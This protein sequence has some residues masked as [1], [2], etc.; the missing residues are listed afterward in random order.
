MSV[1]EIGSVASAYV[2]TVA[3]EPS[4]AV[5]PYSSVT[6]ADEAPAPRASSAP[7][8][9]AEV[10]ETAAPTSVTTGAVAEAT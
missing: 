4:A 8:I 1:A 2:P 5:V 10:P 6:V 9:V 3:D 7:V